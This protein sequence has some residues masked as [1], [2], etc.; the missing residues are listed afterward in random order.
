VCAVRVCVC[1]CAQ[2]VCACARVCACVRVCVCACVRVCVCAC[3]RVC[4]CA[5]VCMCP[6]A[7]VRMRGT[8]EKDIVRLPLRHAACVPSGIAREAG[9][10]DGIVPMYSVYVTC[11][12]PSPVGTRPCACLLPTCIVCLCV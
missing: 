5:C 4:V 7:R 3:V 12:L 10:R 2:C 6:C 11:P 1:A 9:V 8:G